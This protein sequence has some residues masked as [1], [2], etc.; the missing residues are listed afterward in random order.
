MHW[1]QQ[2]VTLE[3]KERGFHLVTRE[4]MRAVDLSDIETGVAHFF[5]QHT[6]AAITLNENASPDVRGDFERH[7][8]RMVPEDAHYEHTIE[9]PDDMPAHLKASLLGSGLSVPIRDG[10]LLLGTW[11]GLYLCEHRERGGPRTLV[12]TAFGQ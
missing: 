12:V 9:G 6:S 8:R 1:I 5:L 10:G 4:V 11:Q 7:F 3:A 2:D